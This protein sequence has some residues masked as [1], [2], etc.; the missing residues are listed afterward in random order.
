[1]TDVIALKESSGGNI[2][3][4]M[5]QIFIRNTYD[6]KHDFSVWLKT[7]SN[8]AEI[9]RIRSHTGIKFKYSLDFRNIDSH[10]ENF[11]PLLTFISTFSVNYHY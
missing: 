6:T 4:C 1:M 11:I 9:I 5:I 10:T 2:I 3:K 8:L 7:G